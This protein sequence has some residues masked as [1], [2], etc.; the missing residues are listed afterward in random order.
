MIRTGLALLFVVCS[1]SLQAADEPPLLP[2]TS[3]PKVAVAKATDAA[4]R[5]MIVLTTQ[6]MVKESRVRVF[7][8]NGKNVEE[9]YE[10]ERPVYETREIEMDG[11]TK[12]NDRNGVVV[13]PRTLPLL[14]KKDTPVLLT[15]D[16]KL[17][18]FYRQLYRDEILVLAWQEPKE[19]PVL[20]QAAP[21]PAIPAAK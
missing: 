15:P 19:A 4:G 16:G 8:V 17:D 9:E 3:P 21:A 7:V 11:S 20:L 6:R 12:V 5:V 10:A 2:T 1:Q 14:L 18:R 13:D